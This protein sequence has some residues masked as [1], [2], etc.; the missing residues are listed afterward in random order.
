MWHESESR[1]DDFGRLSFLVRSQIRLSLADEWQK[2]WLNLEQDFLESDYRTIR[3]RQL[4]MLEKEDGM[5]ARSGVRELK[6][7]LQREAYEVMAEQ[8]SA[9]YQHER[10]YVG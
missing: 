4:E 9:D 2:T 7:R 5:L 1:L 8:R 10:F 3:D 6:E